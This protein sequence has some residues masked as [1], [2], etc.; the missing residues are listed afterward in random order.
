MSKAFTRES[1]DE[2]ANEPLVSG[3]ALDLLPAGAKNY[4]TARGAHRFREEL[5]R[6]IQVDRPRLAADPARAGELR[7]LDA[8]IK[9]LEDNL[10]SAEIVP[11]PEDD[12]PE[13][14]TFGSTVTVREQRGGALKR[15]TIVGVAESDSAAGAISWISPMAKALIRARRGDQVIVRSPAGEEKLEIVEIANEQFAPLV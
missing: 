12:R 6:L 8:R 15:F 2:L 14:V 10:L 13:W 3:S 1:D 7:V 9:E 11:V 4:L 5:A